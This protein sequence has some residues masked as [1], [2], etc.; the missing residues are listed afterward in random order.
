MR[1]E[2]FGQGEVDCLFSKL[3]LANF[4]HALSVYGALDSDLTIIQH[5][6]GRCFK[7][8]YVS[9]R[10]DI[11]DLLERADRKLLKLCSVD[12]D[13][14]LNNIIPKKKETKCNLRNRTACHPDINS[15][16][17]KNVSVNR[18]VFKYHI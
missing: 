13:C 3:V 14:P 18:L 12:P 8:K 16:W 5:F 2:G 1:K 6:V 9:K 10:M 7:R 4:T 17:F 15:A 11:R